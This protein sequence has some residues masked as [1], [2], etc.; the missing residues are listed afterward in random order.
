MCMPDEVLERLARIEEK[1]DGFKIANTI[2]HTQLS[3]SVA[4]LKSRV[5]EEINDHQD[6]LRKLEEKGV[7]S[8]LVAGAILFVSA[9]F[10]VTLINYL[11]R[12][13]F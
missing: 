2:E 12:A 7:K 13:L 9:A 6:R 4:D 5:N 10:V 8:S 1:V 3:Q 11:F